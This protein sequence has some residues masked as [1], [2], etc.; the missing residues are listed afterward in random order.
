MTEAEQ[1]LNEIWRSLEDDHS[2]MALAF[3]KTYVD[4][5]ERAGVITKEAAELWRL[6]MD[7]ECPERKGNHIGGRA[8]CAYCGETPERFEETA[9]TKESK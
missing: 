4:A 2:P 3:C 6:R 1:V 5:Y 9:S 8:W 7:H